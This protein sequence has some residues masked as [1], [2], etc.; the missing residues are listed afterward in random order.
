MY[1]SENFFRVADL[2]AQTKEEPVLAHVQMDL[3]F[4]APVSI[5]NI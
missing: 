5:K 4:V 3:G 2:S 1:V